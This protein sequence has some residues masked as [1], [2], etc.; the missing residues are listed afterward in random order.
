ML[1]KL[2]GLFFKT[3]A[4]N[5]RAFLAPKSRICVP[6]ESVCVETSKAA[7]RPVYTL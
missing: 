2:I 7:T 5:L 6:A 1:N 3:K 4:F